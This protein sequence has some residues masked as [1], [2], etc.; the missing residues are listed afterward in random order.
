VR[1]LG[2]WVLVAIAD[3]LCGLQTGRASRIFSWLEQTEGEG[4]ALKG[5]RALIFALW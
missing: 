4:F 2:G 3:R 1:T 5:N